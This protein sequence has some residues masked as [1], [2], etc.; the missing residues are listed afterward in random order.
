[1]A[2]VICA[3]VRSVCVQDLGDGLDDA[4]F[5]SGVG[6][7]QS[8]FE[9]GE[10]LLDG[11][12]IGRVGR[13]E[14]EPRAGFA[15][16]RA[17]GVAFVASQIVDDHDVAGLERGCKGVLDIGAEPDT[18]DRPV[19]EHRG[20]DAVMAQR[21]QEGER[22]PFAERGPGNKTFASAGPA[23]GTRH[24]GLGPGLIDEHET[25]WIEPALVSLP[26]RAPARHV[27]PVLLGGVETFF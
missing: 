15:D 25:T 4:L 17:D 16:R 27:G 1:M 6:F 11:I 8:R 19:E 7:T 24:V 26:S 5:G 14:E 20:V 18:V 21:R 9:L 3:F 22:S 2:K 10:D 23:T 12:E 13:Q